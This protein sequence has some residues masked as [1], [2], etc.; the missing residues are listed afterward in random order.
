M[1]HP[2][3]PTSQPHRKC[4]RE[5]INKINK[6]C[7][8]TGVALSELVVADGTYPKIHELLATNQAPVL[9][10]GGQQEP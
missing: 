5:T 9:W 1:A 7:A 10:L 4:N 6:T 3:M 8:S 2:S